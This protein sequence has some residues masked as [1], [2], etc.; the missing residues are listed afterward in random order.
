MRDSIF[1]CGHC[2]TPFH[3]LEGFLDHEDAEAEAFQHPQ[4]A[5]ANEHTH[6]VGTLAAKS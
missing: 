3:T 2:G 1:V 6:D 5:G 4:A